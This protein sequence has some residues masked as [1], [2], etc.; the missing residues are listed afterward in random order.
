MRNGARK[1]RYCV[2]GMRV[3]EISAGVQ[4]M[5]AIPYVISR[6]F[7][8]PPLRRGGCKVELQRLYTRAVA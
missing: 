2:T 5:C 4:R 3:T 7:A 6:A 1:W 8:L